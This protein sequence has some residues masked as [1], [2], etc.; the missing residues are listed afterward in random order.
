MTTG[1]K[2]IANFSFTPNN[3]CAS[4]PIQFTDN[5]TTSPGATVKWSWNFGDGGGSAEQNPSYVFHAIGNIAVQLTV[6]NNGCEDDVTKSITVLPPVSNFGYTVNC[7]DHLTVAFIDSSL[8]DVTYGPI[9]YQWDFGDGGTSSSQ[10]PSHTYSSLGTYNVILNVTNGACSYSTT[11]AIVLANE[12]ADFT[13]SKNLVCKNETFT[14]NAVSANPANVKNYTWTIGGTTVTSTNPGLDYSIDSFGTYDV[15]L[16]TEDINGC[17]NSKT[18]ANY[19]TV[20]GP[21]A[22]FV[23][24]LGNCINKAVSFTDSSATNGVPI[25]EWM[26]DFGDGTQQTFTSPPFSH[27]YSQT[28]S[29]S[30][31]LTVKNSNNCTDKYSISNAVLITSPIAGFKADTLYC[32]LAPLQFVDTSTGL[33]LS[34]NWNFGDGGSST[35][36]NPTHSYPSGN[37]S[38]TVK[39]VITDTVGCKDSVTKGS[40]VDIRPPTAAFDIV[41]SAGICLPLLTNF[42]FKG[43]DY[44]SFNWDFGD[45]TSTTAQSPSHFYNDYG[46]FIPK[47]ILTGP[48]GCTDTAQSTV[49]IYNARAATQITVDPT[50]ACNSLTANFD[51]TA[52]PGFKYAFDFDDG[53]IDSSGQANLTHLYPAPGNFFPALTIT[54]EFGCQT[55]I[56]SPVVHVYGAI[57]LF[58]KDK[59]E[60]CDTGLVTFKNFTLS[61]DP[62]VST[63]WNFGDGGSSTDVAPSHF[64]GN[65]G[66]YSVDLTVTTENQCTSSYKDTILV[67]RTPEV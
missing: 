23:S 50:A 11:R 16:I 35:L 27:A 48:G 36:Q 55:R 1:T 13:I 18:V 57:P 56:G 26:W 10:S 62:V 43:V 44:A 33:Q 63:I 59:K 34:Y 41:D 45:G 46:I 29:Y 4:T 7:A 30:V 32:P 25:T 12:P 42:V 49:S 15:S 64:F 6:S 5:S 39:L 38:Y 51:V 67:Y 52:P 31:S 14:L 19:V 60:F 61:N 3:T 22:K 65:P 28:G 24:S 66:L 47:L 40:Y 17:T 21:V 58:G 9:T 2:P 37:N 20:K 54:D 8:T 53:A